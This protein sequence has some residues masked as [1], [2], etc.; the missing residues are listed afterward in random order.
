M[1]S[2]STVLDGPATLSIWATGPDGWGTG[3]LGILIELCPA[4]DDEGPWVEYDTI[5]GDTIVP[6]DLFGVTL[7]ARV[8]RVEGSDQAEVS[9]KW[10][11][12]KEPETP[13][14]TNDAVKLHVAVRGPLG[15]PSEKWAVTFPKPERCIQP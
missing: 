2:I 7:R 8:V 3:S 11:S 10:F 1:S 15:S 12:R 5:T 13:V 4:G 6:L 9:P 14:I